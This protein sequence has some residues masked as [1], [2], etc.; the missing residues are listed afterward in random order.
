M[1]EIRELLRGIDEEAR[2]EGFESALEERARAQFTPEE[3][4]AVAY[5]LD[6]YARQFM[7]N[8]TGPLVDAVESFCDK[9]RSMAEGAE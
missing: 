3:I 6:K 4:A 8:Y 5:V 7:T 9:A 2:H 1:D